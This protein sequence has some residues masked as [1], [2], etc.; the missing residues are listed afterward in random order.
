ME[1]VEEKTNISQVI[2]PGSKMLERMGEGMD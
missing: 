1:E 2:P